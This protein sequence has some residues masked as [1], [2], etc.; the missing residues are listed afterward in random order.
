[1]R[2]PAVIVVTRRTARR[3]RY[4]EYVGEAHL[5]LLLKLKTLPLIVPS[6]RGALPLLSEYRERMR[7]LLLVEGEDIEPRRYAAERANFRYLEKTDP[8][9]DEIELRLL[10]YALQK[11]VAV[12]GICRGSQLLNVISGGTL[13]GD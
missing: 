3:T 1:M 9:K 2:R 13:Y 8:E 11:H 5:E 4:I 6:V 7:G 12:L 10:R